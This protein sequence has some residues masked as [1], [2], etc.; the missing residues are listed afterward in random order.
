MAEVEFEG[1]FGR[2]YRILDWPL[3]LVGLNL[4]WLL[5]VLAGLVVGGLAPSTQALY[6]LLLAYLRGEQVRPWSDFWRVWRATLGSAQLV[7]GMPL[8]TV[9]VVGFYVYASSGTPF[10][11]AA[12]LL[13]LAYL[14]TLIQLP[15][16]VAGLDLPMIKTWQATVALAWR[17]PLHTLGATLLSTALA[18]GAWFIAPAALVVIIP[19]V[20]AL[21]AT[22]IVRRGIDRISNPG[23]LPE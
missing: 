16:A 14:A 10:A 1:R 5:G 15:A 7:I 6:A 11:V 17:Q 21:L 8:L 4:L 2:A 19:S 23:E 22:L 13:A 20:P 18:V 12:V 9:A 3:R